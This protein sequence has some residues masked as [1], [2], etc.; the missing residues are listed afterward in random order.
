MGAVALYQ[1]I[2]THIKYMKHSSSLDESHELWMLKFNMEWK[3]WNLEMGLI[4]LKN[5]KVK[6]IKTN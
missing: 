5:F 2:T 6:T 3:A 1:H 4:C